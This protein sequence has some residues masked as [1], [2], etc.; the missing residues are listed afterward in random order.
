MPR[1]QHHRG[2]IYHESRSITHPVDHDWIGLAVCD[3]V[4]PGVASGNRAGVTASIPAG[5]FGFHPFPA[6]SR[7]GHTAI[8][9]VCSGP[10]CDQFLG[11]STGG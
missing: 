6:R 4:F 1:G 5:A 11:A 8:H 10:V 9:P 2:H 3:G 7:A